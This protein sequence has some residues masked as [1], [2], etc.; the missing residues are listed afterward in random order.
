MFLLKFNYMGV[1][2]FRCIEIEPSDRSMIR[3]LI[4][5]CFATNPPAATRS[6]NGISVSVNAYMIFFSDKHLLQEV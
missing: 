4:W 1:D 3:S 6:V 2:H 5:V